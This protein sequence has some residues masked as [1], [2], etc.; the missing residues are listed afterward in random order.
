MRASVA[1]VCLAHRPR[2]IVAAKLKDS[3][4]RVTSSTIWCQSQ[5]QTIR[6]STTRPTINCSGVETAVVMTASDNEN[7]GRYD[8]WGGMFERP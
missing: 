2:R 7:G 8:G 5:G 3:S 4:S 6:G 1:P